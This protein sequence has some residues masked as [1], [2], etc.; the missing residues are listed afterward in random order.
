MPPEYTFSKPAETSELT[1]MPPGR[2]Y[3]DS[4]DPTTS[5]DIAPAKAETRIPAETKTTP[6][7]MMILPGNAVR[8]GTWPPGCTTI[9]PPAV[10]TA[11]LAVPPPCTNVRPPLSTTVELAT[12]PE[13]TT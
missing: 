7:E 9:P 3:S 6:V 11:K 5:P 12:P 13:K 10:T 2:T 4:L 8:M 1:A